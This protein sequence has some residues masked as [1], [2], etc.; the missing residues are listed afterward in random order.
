MATTYLTKTFG[1]A[2]SLTTWTLSFWIKKTSNGIEQ[3]IFSCDDNASGNNDQWMKFDSAD[4]IQFSQYQSGYTQ[5]IET[6]R[7]FRDTNGF[8]HIVLVW[9][10]TN[11]AAGN[12]TRLYV[13]G[14]RETSF[15]SEVQA[16]SSLGSLINNTTYPLEIGRRGNNN[17]QFF[18]GLLSHVHFIDG[19]AYD[20]SAFGETDTTTGEWVAKTSP[21]VTYGNNG[22]F[23][24]KD[25]NGITDQSGEGNNFT[26]GGGTLTDLK[27]NPDNVFCTLNP[28]E[29]QGSTLSNG[30]NTS[31]HGS[32]SWRSVA[33]TLGMQTGKFYYEAKLVSGSAGQLGIIRADNFPS[34]I[35]ASAG[36]ETNAIGNI[37]GALSV[38]FGDGSVQAAGGSGGTAQG[39]TIAA[40]DIVGCAVDATNNKI[41]WSKNGV[42]GNS[43]NPANGTNAT[44]I[45]SN[46]TDYK[47]LLPAISV[48][49]STISTNFGNGYFGT[50]A[51]TT[52]SNNGYSGAE[53][54]SKFNYTVP[55]GYSAL[56]TKGLNE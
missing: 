33:C 24:L 12:R 5:K 35:G 19:T 45:A 14:V 28:L 34:N 2:G 4:I 50:T 9:D 22:F 40:G 26:L 47:P 52:N 32:A 7:K 15:S 54:S 30:N 48:N 43:S 21:S 29:K 8:Y 51:I 55:T 17:T 39:F 44:T 1:S 42:W 6:N 38:N 18:T 3:R 49:N 25:G 31:A 13:N 36:L 27:D 53:G 16:S 56:S 20:A 46:L 10:T 37:T 23:I 41:Y 11:G